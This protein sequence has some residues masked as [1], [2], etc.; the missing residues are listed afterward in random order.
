VPAGLAVVAGIG[1]GQA[2][3]LGAGVAGPGEAYL[4]LGTSA[5][6]GVFSQAYHTSDCFRTMYS[7][8][9]GA[10]QLEMAVLAGAYTVD[11]FVE[12][13]VGIPQ[14][15]SEAKREALALLEAQAALLPPGADGLLLVPY[16]NSA[17]DPY[18]DAKASGVILG[19]RGVHGKAHIYRAILEGIAY[20][21]RLQTR[22]AESVLGEPVKRF[23]AVGGGAR[24][25]A[26]CQ[27]IADVVGAP[28]VRA[29][30]NEAAALGA[31]ALAAAAAGIY[32]DVGRAARA[33]A[34]WEERIFEPDAARHPI[35]T[36]LYEEVYRQVY[37]ALREPMRRL[38]DLS[39]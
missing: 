33:M 17:M 23:I 32:A 4:S 16:W 27:I 24:S 13:L 38:T 31:G 10:Y 18:W 34:R 8:I 30:E 36:R 5:I 22:G 6:S 25:D 20:E 3:G 11:W 19:W 2:A 28:V 21:K 37:P 35:Y 15:D 12:K 9:P 14:Q 7:G 39:G 26:W 29:L 1:D